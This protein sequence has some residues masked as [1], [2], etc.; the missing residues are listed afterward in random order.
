MAGAMGAPP[1]CGALEAAGYRYV[2]VGEREGDFGL[3]QVKDEA[4]GFEWDGQQHY[5][6][7]GDAVT[8]ALYAHMEKEYRLR[9]DNVG[10]D[11]EPVYV[12][13]RGLDAPV[14]CVLI[15]GSG[16]VTPGMWARSLCINNSCHEGTIF[17]Y[18]KAAAERGWG[19]LV[20]NPN[21]AAPKS[22][23]AEIHVQRL[24]ARYVEPG[25]A[26]H[27]VIVAHSYGGWSTLHYLKTA[28]EEQR[29]RI[30]AVAFTDSVHELEMKVPQG[31]AKVP[32]KATA[33][34]REKAEKNYAEKV[35]RRQRL[36]EL[37]PANFA[38]PSP[39]VLEFL[40]A[41]AKNWIE[42]EKP[43]GARIA[44]LRQGVPTVSAGHKEHVWT[45][46][47]AFPSVF[48]F[49]DAQ[50]PA[51]P[52]T[53][54]E[55]IDL[56]AA[57]KADGNNKLKGGEFKAASLAYKKGNLY[58]KSVLPALKTEGGGE[59]QDEMFSNMADKYTNKQQ[60]PAKATATEADEAKQLCVAINNNLA[61]ARI[62]LEDWKGAVKYASEVLARDEGNV[63][64]HLRR[65]T[66]ALNMGRL[67]EAKTDFEAVQKVD[68]DAVAASLKKLNQA[69]ASMHAKEKKRY[70]NMFQ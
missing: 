18:L 35:Q 27:V 60:K 5:D 42:S 43:V 40:A 19:V 57:C 9:K 12:F 66:A 50:L 48:A 16:A 58:L 29:K 15:Q 2:R 17:P 38:Q 70:S 49:L 67:D 52:N 25:P 31:G 28:T 53:I 68:P 26:E 23:C 47:T 56:A 34:Q 37:V 61:Q 39:A 41:N 22:E 59:G 32:A 14:V 3:R 64:A 44:D 20:A 65:G 1:V 21:T 46:G 6:A 36:K 62:K 54:R 69:Y 4:K 30:K 13:H 33:E 8:E 45:S 10:T 11:E 7:L 55:N 51:R 24:M 63:K